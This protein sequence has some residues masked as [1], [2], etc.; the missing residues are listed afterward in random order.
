[1]LDN[2]QLGITPTKAGMQE[3]IDKVNDWNAANG[4][5]TNY[6]IDNYA[7]VQSALIDYI[8][9]QGL[10]GYAAMEGSS[11]FEGSMNSM[12]GAWQNV[13]TSLTT[14][15]GDVQEA[16]S[17]L[18]TT[19]SNFLFNNFFPMLG[20]IVS[21]I[22]TFIKQFFTAAVPQIIEGLKGMFQQLG[23]HIANSGGPSVG[24]RI[25]TAL[26]NA[27]TF[28]T[29]KFPEIMQRG[30]DSVRQFVAGWGQGDGHVAKAVG[31]TIGKVIKIIGMAAGQ[32]ILAGIQM[33]GQLIKGFF[34][35]LPYFLANIGNMIGSMI[36]Q[37]ASSNGKFRNLG[38]NLIINLIN[39]IASLVTRVGST[40]RNIATNAINAFK[41][42]D[43]GS[44]GR[45]IISGIVR[46]ITGAAS[47]LFNSLR[48]LAS[49]ALR[50]AQNALKIKSPSRVFANEVGKWIPA[51]MAVGIEANT[52]A[53]TSAMNDLS[54]ASV[55]AGIGSL[56]T[57][58]LAD[59][60]NYGSININV[61]GAQ[62]Q[63]VNTLADA[64]IS[65]LQRSI[66]G[67]R[68]VYG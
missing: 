5:A 30:V 12:K 43:W 4:E 38:V 44:V 14:G 48:N 25:Q 50:S 27:L 19:V 35:N 59:Q 31:E 47:N 34:Q 61:Y 26:D 28:L 53:V 21:N 56:A 62:G 65:K 17:A 9:M 24:E 13:L 51:G 68:V 63:D 6:V 66:S 3:V 29:T 16:V 15:K 23:D 41:G 1:M 39:G 49:N 18:G 45:N 11:T 22:P 46:G 33:L 36:K 42:I 64:V 20:M 58:E 57:G 52:S 2:L 54:N 40:M 37:F 67:R 60:N 32:L 55:T 8:E 10:A 7:D